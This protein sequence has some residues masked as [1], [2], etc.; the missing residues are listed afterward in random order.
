VLTHQHA[1]AKGTELRLALS[2]RLVLRILS[3]MGLDGYFSVYPTV[4]EAQAAGTASGEPGA[5]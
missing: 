5:G 4:A 2:S 3:T 1:A